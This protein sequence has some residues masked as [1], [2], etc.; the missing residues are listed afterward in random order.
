MLR[1]IVESTAR[2]FVDKSTDRWGIDSD[3][4]KFGERYGKLVAVFMTKANFK[5]MN[6][7]ERWCFEEGDLPDWVQQELKSGEKIVRYI[8]RRSLIS[9]MAPLIKID[10][11]KGVVYFLKDPDA[12]LSSQDNEYWEFEKRPTKLEYMRV[13]K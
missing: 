9:G 3:I 7:S 6:D 11:K 12:N 5:A 4:R 1:E 10:T 2:I 13:V 8:T